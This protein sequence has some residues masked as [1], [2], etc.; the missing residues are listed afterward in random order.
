MA[1][2]TNIARQHT[3]FVEYLEAWRLS[4]L[5]T[6]PYGAGINLDVLRGRV[7]TLT[8]LRKSLSDRT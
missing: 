3:V 8:E 6:L 7:Q 1:A 5:E 2:M 4:E